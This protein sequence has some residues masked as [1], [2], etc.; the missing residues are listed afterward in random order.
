MAVE[1]KNPVE[2]KIAEIEQRWLEASS[3]AD[4]RLFIWR[5]PQESD[6][7]IHGFFA[8]QQ[9]PDNEYSTQ[10]L[11]IN[12]Q[13]P[14]EIAYQYCHAIE[15]AFIE[16]YES[17]DIEGEKW[18]YS[19][20]APCYRFTELNAL[21]ESFIAHHGQFFRYLT[22]VLM[23]GQI[24]QINAFTTWL[25]ECLATPVA[26]RIRFV[27]TD[28]TEE[29][30]WQ[31]LIDDHLK[32]THLIEINI[33]EMELM[34]QILNES[35]TTDGVDMLRF[36]Q[37][38][39]DTFIGLSNGNTSQLG[40]R[41]Q[42]A[43][44]I[45]A[46]NNWFD[47][48]VVMYSMLAGVYLKNADIPDAVK[49]YRLA[50]Q[51]A[52][53]IPLE[54][55][56]L[57]LQTQS[58]FGEAGA[59]FMGKEYLHASEAYYSAALLA[60]KLPQPLWVIEGYR[61]SGFSLLEANVNERLNEVVDRYYHAFMAGIA[62]PAD[63]RMQS[64]FMFIFQDIMRLVDNSCVE[65]LVQLAEV[66][67]QR[68][69]EI[70][71]SIEERQK[72]LNYPPSAS[73]IAQYD[74]ELEQQMVKLFYLVLQAREDLIAQAGESFKQLISIARFYSHP[75]WSVHQ[76][77]VHPFDE[78]KEEWL[79]LTDYTPTIEIE[80]DDVPEAFYTLLKHIIIPDKNQGEAA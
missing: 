62:L 29:Q 9:Q 63:E 19:S 72:S 77:I 21:L 56:Q 60:Q 34:R 71:S 40:V 14:Y 70:I 44:D 1:I 13:E 24:S 39:V 15:Q 5:V 49:N 69:G 31:P 11:F 7:L 46:K 59:W 79:P 57:L 74:D 61:V 8:L 27:V 43:I 22:I 78:P 41:A 73:Q 68:Q 6:R 36:R 3:N 12:F 76:D 54:P 80:D 23:P 50:Q 35:P 16:R 45:A 30:V 48:Q 51:A 37:L 33:D 4:A 26:D 52:T 67:Y 20:L 25:G 38:M 2:R 17:T 65:K 32:L 58:L 47:Q 64:T 42:K 10:D 18:A 66:Y 75:Y 28:T 55:Q 53:N